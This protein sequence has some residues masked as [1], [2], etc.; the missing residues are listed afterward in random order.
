MRL[1]EQGLYKYAENNSDVSALI[2]EKKDLDQEIEDKLKRLIENYKE[3]LDY[4]K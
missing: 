3:T 2:L 4:L 1:F